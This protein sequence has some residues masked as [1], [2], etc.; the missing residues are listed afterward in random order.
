MNGGLT[1]NGCYFKALIWYLYG[2][3][4]DVSLVEI[5]IEFKKGRRKY[6]NTL[7]GS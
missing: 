7:T 3:T 6:G 1:S 5:L 4:E 2:E